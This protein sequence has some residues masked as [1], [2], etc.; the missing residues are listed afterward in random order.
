M[1]RALWKLVRAWW[2]VDRI[3]IS[4]REGRLLGLEPGAVLQI[5]E[6]R[7]VVVR[8]RPLPGHRGSAAVVYE[9]QTRTGTAVLHARRTDDESMELTWKDK[10]HEHVVAPERITIY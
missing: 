9:C 5:G 1:F 10:E 6:T 4:P 2:R 7:A 8:R 3:R